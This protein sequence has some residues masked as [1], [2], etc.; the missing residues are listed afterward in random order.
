MKVLDIDMDYFMFSVGNNISEN[1]NQRYEE[2]NYGESVW[3]EQDV[4]AFLENNLGLS[5]IHKK[6]GRLLIHHNEALFFWKELIEDGRLP[7][8]F[9][10]IHVDSHADLGLGLSCGDR[11]IMRTLLGLD[12]EQRDDFNRYNQLPNSLMPGIGD[13]LLFAIAFRWI[14]KLTYCS[15]PKGECNDFLWFTMKNFNEPLYYG[16]FVQNHIQLLYNPDDDLPAFSINREGYQEYLDNSIKEPEVPFDII[17]SIEMV[18]Y[19]GDF[20]Y[21]TLAQSP[22]YTPESADFILEIIKDYIEEI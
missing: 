16:D 17:H 19:D 15:N 10:V 6:P 11:F 7:Y 13:Y 20:D 14:S 4:R 5:Q 3:N 18:N 2:D 12:V 9:E 8:P 1:S 22:N 21:I